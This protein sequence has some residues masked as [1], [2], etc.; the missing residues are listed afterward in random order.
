MT[1]RIAAVA[2]GIGLLAILGA[3]GDEEDRAAGTAPD[4]PGAT[5]PGSMGTLPTV[6]GTADGDLVALL[7]GREFLSTAVEGRALAAGTQV[8]LS[9]DGDQLGVSPGCNSGGSTFTID[10]DQLVIDGI[11]MTEMACEPAALMDQDAW[12]VELLSG[13]PTLAVDGETL[14]VAGQDVSITFTGP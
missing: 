8:R 10:G 13:R 14:T 9:F 12:V 5:S 4:P 11:A 2:L 1:S 6:P 3:C 7:D